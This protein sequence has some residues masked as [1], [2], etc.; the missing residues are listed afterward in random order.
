MEQD[1]SINLLFF[2]GTAILFLFTIFIILMVTKQ[3][4]RH[5]RIKMNAEQAEKQHRENLLYS[6]IQATETERERIARDLHDEMGSILSLTSLK[7]KSLHTTKDNSVE[8][9]LHLLSEA[10]RNARELSNQTYPTPLHL[11]GLEHVLNIMIGRAVAVGAPIHF[12]YETGTGKLSKELSL[13]VYRIVQELLSNSLKYARASSIN[14]LIKEQNGAIALDYTDN[15]VGTDL[16]FST[17]GFGFNNI[18][19]R[20]LFVHGTFEMTSSA[21]KGFSFRASIPLNPEI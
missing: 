9:V 6:V 20:M 3:K 8:E 13:S 17:P 4:Q 15:G 7:L 16:N 21:G 14:I 1:I 18:R 2:S 11:F 19:S 12:S 5:L 10:Q